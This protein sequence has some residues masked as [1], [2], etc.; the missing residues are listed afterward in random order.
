MKH[1][2]RDGFVIEKI[3]GGEQQNAIL[4]PSI[5]ISSPSL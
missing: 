2:E 5:I 3:T 4:H 1:Q